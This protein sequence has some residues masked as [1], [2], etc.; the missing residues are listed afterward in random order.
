MTSFIGDNTGK[1]DTKGRVVF[2]SSFK[3]QM[4]DAPVSKFVIK[5]DIFEKC[6]I[7]YPIQE[8]KRQMDILKAK[9]NPYN[10]EHNRFLR[11]FHRGTAEVNLD[12]NNRLL[13]PARLLEYAEI[14]KE[15]NFSGQDR[16]IEIWAKEVYENNSQDSDDF[17]ELAEK[18]MGSDDLPV[19]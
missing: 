2:P 7:L 15:I 13:I 14:D 3:K 6:L 19:I 9:L 17:A 1:I 16:K 12:T 4:Q 8:W 10:R 18:I 11:E 5:K